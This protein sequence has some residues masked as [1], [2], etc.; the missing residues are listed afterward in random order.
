MMRGE[1]LVPMTQDVLKRI[2]AEG[3]P[4][5]S[6]E[7]C[8]EANFDDLDKR[9]LEAFRGR[10]A[11]KSPGLDLAQLTVEQLLTDADLFQPE[12]GLTYA[13]LILLGTEKALTRLLGQGELIFEYRSDSAS[14]PYQQ[15]QDFRRG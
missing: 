1:S 13:A 2:F 12:K 5:F 14:I 7:V 9:A 6:A 8:L 4:D 3:Q 11:A 15:R 10:W